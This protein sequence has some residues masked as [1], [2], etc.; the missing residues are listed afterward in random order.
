MDT[1]AN[2]P[3]ASHANIRKRRSIRSLVV[4]FFLIARFTIT[5]SRKQLPFATAVVRPTRR[6]GPQEFSQV[7]IRAALISGLASRFYVAVLNFLSVPI[8]LRWLGI[9]A[10]GL[11]GLITTIQALFSVVEIALS[12]VVTQRTA[13][14]PNAGGA[15]PGCLAVLRGAERAYWIST[16]FVLVL[17]F[18]A[19]AIFLY[20]WAESAALGLREATISVALLGA[21]SAL[22]WPTSYYSAVLYGLGRQGTVALITAATWTA[23]I[24]VG[25]LLLL[26][27]GKQPSIFFAWQAVTALLG[28]IA[29]RFAVRCAV[30][31]WRTVTGTLRNTARDIGTAVVSVSAVTAAVLVFNQ[32]D[33]VIVGKLFTLETFGYYSLAWQLAGAVSLVSLPIY[34]AYLPPISRAHADGNRTLLARL[35][36]DATV[37]TAALVLPVGA[38]V[39]FL[40]EP[41]LYAWTGDTT[42]AVETAVFLKFAFAGAAVNALIYAAFAAQMATHK[43]F[44]TLRAVLGSIVAALPLMLVAASELGVAGVVAAW[45]ITSIAQ[46][47]A[48]LY[49]TAATILHLPVGKWAWR[50]LAA[51]ALPAIGAMAAIQPFLPVAPTRWGSSVIVMGAFALCYATALGL[52]WRTVALAFAGHP[53]QGVREAQAS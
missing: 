11:I 18:A 43:T 38:G 48:V 28:V 47:G 14:L 10:M 6:V 30:P 20:G 40:A 2:P 26:L 22:L 15:R 51:I 45:A 32:M 7:S 31:D 34:T 12:G 24:G 50:N 36:T 41:L 35:V 4:L 16:P 52:N 5:L 44:I 29:L 39:V 25:L 3:S 46:T 19:A 17:S 23:R 42:T 13:T 27:L 8:L 33:K 53:L 9:E 21:S 37:V 49:L 1:G